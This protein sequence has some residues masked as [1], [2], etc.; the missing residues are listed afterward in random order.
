[1]TNIKLVKCTNL[2]WTECGFDLRIPRVSF[3][4]SRY[5]SIHS[6]PLQDPLSP[7]A[8]V[9]P[10]P[11]GKLSS[12]FFPQRSVLPAFKLHIS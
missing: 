3:T 9:P 1:M 5:R 12:E 7:A 4:Q 2:K 6:S 11:S 8:L 10:T